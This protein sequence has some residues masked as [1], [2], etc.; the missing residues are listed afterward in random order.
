[1]K[2]TDVKYTLQSSMDN[3]GFNHMTIG[4]LVRDKWSLDRFTRVA[5]LR[6]QA[7]PGT[8]MEWY[9]GR[10]EMSGAHDLD[11]IKVAT[12]ALKIFIGRGRDFFQE[13]GFLPER[14]AKIERYIYDDRVGTFISIEDVQP[15][16]ILAWRDCHK[17]DGCTVGCMA[18]NDRDAKRL[19]INE[20]AEHS[21][22]QELRVWLESG[23]KVRHLQ[24]NVPIVTPLSE[25]FPSEEKEE[26]LSDYIA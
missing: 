25:L 20:F 8:P 2:Q 15:D 5:E 21:T 18:R 23:Q 9:G 19:L 4:L 6:Y 24:R 16:N 26:M 22:P 12:D 17:P 10:F 3:Q 7:S 14:L 11:D 1:M 13:A